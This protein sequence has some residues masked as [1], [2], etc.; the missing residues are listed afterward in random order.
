MQILGPDDDACG[1]CLSCRLL[2]AGSH[3]DFETIH[4]GLHKV[5]PDRAVRAR[6]AIFISVDVIRHFLIDAAALSPSQ[7]AWRVF[8]VRDAERMNEAAQN[9]LLKTLEEPSGQVVIIL[10]T[11]SSTR[12]LSTIRSRCQCV[13]FDLLPP[14][15]IADELAARAEL[16]PASARALA[17]LA[18]G[19][20]GLALH[21]HEAGLLD[22]LGPVG[23]ALDTLAGGATD[24]FGRMFDAE[25]KSL[26][27]TLL[28]LE[29]RDE[30]GAG[31]DGPEKSGGS[32][33][34]REL[35][36]AACRD[37][38][39]LLLQLIAAHYRDAILLQQGGGNA[40][41]VGGSARVDRPAGQCGAISSARRLPPGHQQR[42][43]H[44]RPQ[45]A[46]RA[47]SR[48]ARSRPAGRSSAGL[49]R[50]PPHP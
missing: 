3:P 35:A 25:A 43:T 39:K 20:L 21:Y 31:A 48:S 30:G 42:G 33:P 50:V 49:T 37:A 40:D 5:H 24:A 28:E 45:R 7:G 8:I 44:A 11:S 1:K 13:P 38:A 19:R 27:S 47:G 46:D 26:G 10:V 22:R 4:R 32:S 17:A 41:V 9:A 14:V 36:P 34:D 15:F 18:D 23:E 29:A 2:E 12:L 16:P 6:T